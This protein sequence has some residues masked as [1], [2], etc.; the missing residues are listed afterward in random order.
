VLLIGTAPFEDLARLEASTEG[1][2]DLRM[3]LFGPVLGDV[4][5]DRVT[6]RAKEMAAEIKAL[7]P[8]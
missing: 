8:T 7:L 5:A 4:P 2:D 6:A 1:L 3:M